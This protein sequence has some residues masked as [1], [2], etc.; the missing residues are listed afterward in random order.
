MSIINCPNCDKP[1]SSLIRLC[2]YCGFQRGEVSDEE[3]R[4]FRRRKLRD[5]VYHLKMTSYVIM[6]LFLGA[7]GWY[8]FE[9]RGFTRLSSMGPILLLALTSVAYI[10]VRVYVFRLQSALRKIK[11]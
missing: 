3:L 4:E 1:V 5:R 8:W 10:A 9:T 7:F 11:P 6:T 2:P